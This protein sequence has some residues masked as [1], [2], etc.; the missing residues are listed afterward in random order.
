MS[1]IDGVTWAEGADL[2]SAF[3]NF[4]PDWGTQN[5]CS[6]SDGQDAY[7]VGQRKDGAK[8]ITILPNK[9]FA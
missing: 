6:A 8:G 2:T 4:T 9:Y 7:L 1:S 5:I 3:A